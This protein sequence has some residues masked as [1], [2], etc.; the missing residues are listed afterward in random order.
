M[1]QVEGGGMPG[2]F[3]EQ[4]GVGA[5]GGEQQEM[6]KGRYQSR[7]RGSVRIWAFYFYKVETIEQ[8]NKM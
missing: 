3:W 7:R 8:G 2:V 4:D 5:E 6:R 1:A